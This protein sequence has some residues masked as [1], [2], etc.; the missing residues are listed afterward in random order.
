MDGLLKTLL[1][2]RFA[3][4]VLTILIS[5][6]AWSLDWFGLTYVCPFCRAQRT[7]IGLLG[8]LLLFPGYGHWLIRYMST[9]I[10]FFAMVVASNQHFS[11]WRRISA[12]EFELNDPWYYDAF[13]LSGCALFILSAQVWLLC[14][15]S[16]QSE[17]A[18]HE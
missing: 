4:G 11:G 9:T 3:I 1:K 5:L 8:V 13:L 18:R 6:G 15:R 17:K 2:Q 7:V 16:E 10:G 14:I 12:G